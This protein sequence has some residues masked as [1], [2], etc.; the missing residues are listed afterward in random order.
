[1][2]Q[3]I[4]VACAMLMAV[5]GMLQA[6]ELVNPHKVRKAH[7]MLAK[8]RAQAHIDVAKAQGVVKAVSDNYQV[9]RYPLLWK[10]GFWSKP[11]ETPEGVIAIADAGLKQIEAQEEAER[12]FIKG[13]QAIQ[14][15]ED[16]LEAAKNPSIV[17]HKVAAL[18]AP[19]HFLPHGRAEQQFLER[20]L[21]V[22]CCGKLASRDLR[23]F[24]S[25]ICVAFGKHS[26]TM[27]KKHILLR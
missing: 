16:A 13:L 19:V 8:A 10:L 25:L 4:T 1:M 18:T 23:V 6:G 27:G 26:K 15:R 9:V 14:A 17:T 22:I 24:Q 5:G 20:L 11:E 21:V 12:V 7:L 2:N 3:R